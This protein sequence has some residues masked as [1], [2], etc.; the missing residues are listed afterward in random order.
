MCADQSALSSSNPL[1]ILKPIRTPRGF[2]IVPIHYSHDPEK[3]NNWLLDQRQKYQSERDDWESDWDREMEMDF[4]SVIGAV[5]Y[6]GFRPVNLLKDLEYSVS[7]PLCLTMD[8]NVEPMIWEVAQ[9]CQNLICFIQE[10]KLASNAS[11]D[12]MVRLFRNLYP[13]HQGELHIFGDATGNGKN[14]QTGKS[15][16]DL[17]RL[18]MRGYPAQ[19]VWKVPAS[20]PPVIDRV[21]ALNLKLRG[22]D[23]QVG[24]L[25]DPDKCPELVK[26]L[27]EV[28]VRDGRIVKI[29]N[30]NDPYF[31]R[32]H[33]SD[34]ASYLVWREW[35]VIGELLKTKARRRLPRV[36][37]NVLGNLR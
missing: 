17:F 16:Y 31:Y 21:N 24:V 30:R 19:L 9:V 11:I 32:T 8:F 12:E 27:R 37:Q 36:Y 23:G 35:P 13:A 10:I 6:T 1:R 7:L 14:A 15:C 34:S 25:I 4:T 5:A 22:V 3:D 2:L 26:D 20:N 29:K 28:K 33:A 18:Y